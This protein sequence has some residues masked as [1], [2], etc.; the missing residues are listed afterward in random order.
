[1]IL[2]LYSNR[3]DEYWSDCAPLSVALTH[4]SPLCIVTQIQTCCDTEIL[5]N[6]ER[7]GFPDEC[8]GSCRMHTDLVAVFQTVATCC[9][10]NC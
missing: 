3:A 4:K 7:P 9:F 8:L 10:F 1:M 5:L 6:L 2:L